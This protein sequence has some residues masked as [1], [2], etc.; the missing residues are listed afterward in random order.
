MQQ[1]LNSKDRSQA[2]IKFI[3]FFLVSV[4]LVLLAVYFNFKLPVKENEFYKNEMAKQIAEN[5]KQTVFVNKMEE[6][7][8]KMSVMK[9]SEDSAKLFTV[10]VSNL[11][12][13]MS[14]LTENSNVLYKKMNLAIFDNF[15]D[16]N[17]KIV[18]Y[19]KSLK[20]QKAVTDLSNLFK[21]TMKELPQPTQDRISASNPDV[22]NYLTEQP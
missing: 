16:L 4:M 1:I 7:V 15:T 12:G 19:H 13:E 22:I 2:F 20:Y 11:L 21:E 6:V 14:S 17:A 18:D 3:L 8:K 5:D 10:A 9:K